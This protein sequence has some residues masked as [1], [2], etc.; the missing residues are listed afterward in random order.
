M[1]ARQHHRERIL[2]TA[3]HQHGLGDAP[4]LPLHAVDRGD[5]AGA[6]ITVGRRDLTAGRGTPGRIVGHGVVGHASARCRRSRIRTVPRECG[7]DLVGVGM[8][9]F[10]E[11]W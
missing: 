4:F 6:G 3:E 11:D 9:E 10:F 8:L 1:P 5:L 7:S 2:V